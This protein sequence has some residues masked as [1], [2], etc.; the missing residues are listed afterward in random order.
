MK[1]KMSLILV[2]LALLMAFSA[3]ERKV[4]PIISEETIGNI[5]ELASLKCYFNN[6]AIIEKNANNIFQVDRKMWIEYAGVVTLGIRMH[7]LGIQITDD[8]ITFVMPEVCILS[9]EFNDIGSDAYVENPDTGWDKNPI[10]TEE[11]T[12][13]IHESQEKMKASVINN[14][15]LVAKAERQ[16][17]KAIEQYIKSISQLSG[18]EYTIIWKDEE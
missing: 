14:A 9:S 16:V 6:V 13:A 18:Q 17:K 5:C 4:T 7:E 2:L 3:C 15:A 8:S 1:K 11:Q 12:K 10:T